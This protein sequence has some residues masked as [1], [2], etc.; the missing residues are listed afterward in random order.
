MKLLFI[1]P[2]I[3]LFFVQG[4]Q[5]NKENTE[6][7]GID[8]ADYKIVRSIYD[9]ALSNGKSY[10]NLR[11]LCKTV[12]GRLSGSE[13]AAKAVEWAKK[14]MEDAGFDKVYLQEV[15]VPHWVRGEKESAHI[16]GSNSVGNK[17]LN[18]CALGGSVATDTN[19]ITAAVVEVKTFEELNSMDDNKVKGKIVFFNRPMNPNYLSTYTAYGDAVE[20]RWA[21]P[22]LAA[23]RGAVA[24]IV[25]SMTLHLDDYPHTGAMHY[26]DS[27]PKIPSVAVST[28][29]AEMISRLLKKENEVKVFLKISCKLLPDEKSYN[30]IGEMKGSQFPNEIIAVGGH[31][32]S[33]DTGEGA[34]D[35][36]AGCVQAIEALRLLKSLDI[37]SKR[38]LRAVMFMNE[39]NGLNGGKKYA[40]ESKNKPE[41]HIAA[42]E[43]DGGAGVPRGFSIQA[44]K[45]K[46]EHFMMWKELLDSFALYELRTGWSGADIGPLKSDSV[47]LFGLIPESQ[48]YFDY[49]HAATDVFENVHKREL[50]L[51]GAAMAALI[52]MIDKD[53]LRK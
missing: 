8:S 26:N 4:T 42:I 2:A 52:Y 33:W 51:G 28:N 32:D 1:L 7:K 36:G 14:T 50:E 30:V 41:N 3:A 40:E 25:R 18:V 23:K 46:T 45:E 5:H 47:A 20:Q 29:D 49:H 9:E 31:L 21:G 35:D 19:G 22:S 11:V 24:M 38:T 13:Q 17:I 44:N 34:H 53:G 27:F 10:D 6:S 16:S 48:R 12:G 39:E 37:K 43:S 15:M